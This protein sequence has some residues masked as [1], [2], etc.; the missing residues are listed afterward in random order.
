ML[1]L[2][3]VQ[4]P[5]ELW[6]DDAEVVHRSRQSG[7]DGEFISVRDYFDFGASVAVSAPAS[8][9]TVARPD[10]EEGSE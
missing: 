4:G 5:L 3:G 1:N 8:A 10:L 6:V 9:I 2:G 7:E